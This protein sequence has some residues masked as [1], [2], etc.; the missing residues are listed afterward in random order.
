MKSITADDYEDKEETPME[1]E[2]LRT[3][4]ARIHEME[5]E[6]FQLDN[7]LKALKLEKKIAKRRKEVG[8][9][10]RRSAFWNKK[11]VSNFFADMGDLI[12]KLWRKEE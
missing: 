6:L 4:A 5:V 7:T 2:S 10:L 9:S 1:H 12:S 11:P 3:D 8:R